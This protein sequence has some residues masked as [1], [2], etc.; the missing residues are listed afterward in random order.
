MSKGAQRYR[1]AETERGR[2]GAAAGAKPFRAQCTRPPLP[3]G[4]EQLPR[5]ASAALE[6]PK[7]LVSARL[8][9]QES[10]TPPATP[11]GVTA[12]PRRLAGPGCR[13]A[14]VRIPAPHWLDGLRLAG[15]LPKPQGPRAYKGRPRHH[16]PLTYRS[17]G[18]NSSKALSQAG[19]HHCEAPSPRE[20]LSCASGRVHGARHR[21]ETPREGNASGAG[22]SEPPS[23]HP[24]PRLGRRGLGK[25]HL[26]P[27]ISAS[28]RAPTEPLP[29][30]ISSERTVS[31]FRDCWPQLVI[32][33]LASVRPAPP[34]QRDPER[35]VW[36]AAG[37]GGDRHQPCCPQRGA[38]RRRARRFA[39]G[40]G[41]AAGDGNTPSNFLSG[42][43][44]LPPLVNCHLLL[45]S[46]ENETSSVDG[47]RR[48]WR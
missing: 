11:A 34:V 33:R 17:R 26:A 13:A 20:H 24:E 7:D 48:W 39:G 9:Q 43:R 14:G 25:G 47:R 18:E 27:H 38:Q 15:S 41:R 45:F 37:G 2:D 30:E 42:T 36:A 19:R 10:E 29:A 4:L 40:G 21:T 5:S 8:H 22:G 31:T 3:L 44:D 1:E 32:V 6:K 28:R 46:W 16:R 12:W 23:Q 35:P